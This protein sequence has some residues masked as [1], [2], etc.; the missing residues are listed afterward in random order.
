MEVHSVSNAHGTVYGQSGAV[1][2]LIPRVL[3]CLMPVIISVIALRH[4][5]GLTN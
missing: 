1:L 2:K 3:Y 4:V 5:I